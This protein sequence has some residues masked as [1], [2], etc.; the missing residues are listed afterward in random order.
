MT[1]KSASKRTSALKRGNEIWYDESE[2]KTE[3]RQ[4]LKEDWSW[5]LIEPVLRVVRG[6]KSLYT[7]GRGRGSRREREGKAWSYERDRSRRVLKEFL[8]ARG[9]RSAALFP[10]GFANRA[11]SLA[12]GWKGSSSETIPVR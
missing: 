2:I 6:Q 10:M 9:V 1:T 4:D 11:R 7:A 12:N 5:S 8:V 3:W